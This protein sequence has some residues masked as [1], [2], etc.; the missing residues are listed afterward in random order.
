M[1][2][3]LKRFRSWTMQLPSS[4]GLGQAE[5]HS[6]LLITLSM[7]SG[8]FLFLSYFRPGFAE[9]RTAALSLPVVWIV[10]LAV[11]I[12]AQQLAIGEFSNDTETMVGPSGNLQTDYE[13][14]PSK[15]VLAYS[16]SGQLASLGLVSLGLIVGAAMT[17][18]ASTSLTMSQL[19]DLHG[20]WGSRAWATQI[21]WVNIFLFGLHCLPTVPFDMRASVFAF[22]NRRSR[23]AQEPFVFRRIA[24]FDSH[25][26]AVMFGVGC[27]AVALGWAFGR[28]VVGWYAAFAAAVYLFVASQWEAARAEELEEQYAPTP[29]RLTRHDSAA[30]LA[31]HLRLE[32]SG[33]EEVEEQS[34]EAIER[35]TPVAGAK[36]GEGQRSSSGGESDVDE[37]LRKLHKEGVDSLSP[38]ERQALLSASRQINE[39]RGQAT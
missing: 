19:F 4:W 10:S 29:T 21:M 38:D 3:W 30:R 33:G 16:V 1:S 25:L 6:S 17:S 22:F 9:L 36:D 23:N 35:A 12:A 26:A 7:L 14:L 24:S 20:G 18:P 5:I 34:E 31:T 2:G 11:R 13:Y 15:A 8:L 28:E 37:I 32:A 27:A 39:K